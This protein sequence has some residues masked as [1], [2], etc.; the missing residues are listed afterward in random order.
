[1]LFKSNSSIF[2][3]CGKINDLKS[4]GG[5]GIRAL[6]ISRSAVL[7]MGNVVGRYLQILNACNS[8][9]LG[10]ISTQPLQRL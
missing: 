7:L 4:V 2:F 1:M 3:N 8:N 6:A 9:S 5:M 10:L